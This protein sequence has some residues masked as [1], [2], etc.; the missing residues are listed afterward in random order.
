MVWLK[1]EKYKGHKIYFKKIKEFDGTIVVLA[2]IDSKKKESTPY[3]YDKKTAFEEAKSA[4]ND[5]NIE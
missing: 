2:F 3:G 5:D 4:I 1:T